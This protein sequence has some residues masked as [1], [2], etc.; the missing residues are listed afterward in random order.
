MSPTLSRRGIEAQIALQMDKD[1]FRCF[2]GLS[3]V[4]VQRKS[5]LVEMAGHDTI[6]L[7]NGILRTR[8]KIS[9]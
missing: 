1:P 8:R 4:L 3:F 9:R 2:F 6:P 7:N 5:R